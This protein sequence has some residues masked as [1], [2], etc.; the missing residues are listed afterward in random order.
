MK[1]SGFDER[2]TE[3]YVLVVLLSVAAIVAFLILK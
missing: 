2:W 3:V 1:P